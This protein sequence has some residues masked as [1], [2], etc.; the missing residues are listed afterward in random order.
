MT[1][2]RSVL[3]CDENLGTRRAGLGKWP[4][5]HRDGLALHRD[6]RAG[7]QHLGAVVGQLRRLAHVQLRD[8]ARVGHHARVG[9]E[10]TRHVL[11]QS[12]PAGIQRAAKQRGGQI[13]AAA[14]QGNERRRLP[15]LLVPSTQKTRHH[16]HHAARHERPQP[17]AHGRI[18]ARE[19]GRG[20]A[21]RTVGV[22]HFQ[23]IHD[24]CLHTLGAQ[25][26]TEDLRAQALATRHHQIAGARGQ[27]AQGNQA[28]GQHLELGHR[29]VDHLGQL[30]LG[31]LAENQLAQDHA[32]LLAHGFQRERGLLAIARPRMVGHRQQQVGHACRCRA[33]HG[34]PRATRLRN[35]GRM[36]VGRAVR[37]RRAAKLVN[38]GGPRF[39][40]HGEVAF[41]YRV[42]RRPW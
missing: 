26:R 4:H 10:Q 21:K 20:A 24:L 34:E 23:R 7:V 37:K 31:P 42:G 22:N 16:R 40:F 30:G 6:E 29:L 35:A 13:R 36:L 38:L 27:L 32:V 25:H 39:S 15:V 19:V 17:I 2:C 12:H 28:A 33:H 14:A 11:P 41:Y 18:G 8:H 5:V 3:W 9:G 1:G